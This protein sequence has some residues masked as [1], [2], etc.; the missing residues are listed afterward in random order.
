MQMIHHLPLMGNYIQNHTSIMSC[1]FK[2]IN[3]TINASYENDS[4]Y[5]S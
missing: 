4:G 2:A 3:V 5:V 1:V